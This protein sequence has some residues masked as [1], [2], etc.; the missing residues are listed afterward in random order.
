MELQVIPKKEIIPAFDTQTIKIQHI[1]YEDASYH[2]YEREEITEEVIAEL[3]K[4]IPVELN[5]YLSLVPYGEDDWLEV[6][7]NGEWLALG[8][9]SDNGQNNYYS[10]NSDFAN[11]E[12][13]SPLISGGQ[14]PIEKYLAIKDIEAGIKAVEYFIRT[15]ELYPGIDWAKQLS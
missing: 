1:E 3:L 9:S 8:Y 2:D 14:S 12:E 6:I 11:T 7:S 5:V 13:M 4:R 15:G 10:Y